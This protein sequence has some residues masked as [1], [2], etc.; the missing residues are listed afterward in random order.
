MNMFI[1]INSDYCHLVTDVIVD[2]W[3]QAELWME[4]IGKKKKQIALNKSFKIFECI[5]LRQMC[6][7]IM[8]PLTKQFLTRSIMIFYLF[9]DVAKCTIIVMQRQIVRSSWN[10]SCHIFG[11]VTEGN[12]FVVNFIYII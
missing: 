6:Y 12:H 5:I 4:L 10:T 7:L 11:N 9:L 8:L 2:F 3:G 1:L